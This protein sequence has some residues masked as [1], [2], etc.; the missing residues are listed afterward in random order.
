VDKNG[1]RRCDVYERAVNRVLRDRLLEPRRAAQFLHGPRQ[2][3]KTTTVL[4]VL[5][6]LPLKSHYAS[7]DAPE[8]QT[9]SWIREQ[10]EIARG[11]HRTQGTPV[12]LALDEVQKVAL[13]SDV[14][15]ALWDE[16][17][18]AGR[19]IRVTLLGSAPWPMGRGMRESMAGRYE[20]VR[21]TH[22]TFPECR[23]AFGWDLA[24]FVFF[25][26]YPGAVSF[27]GDWERWRGYVMETAIEATVSRDVLAMTRIDK[28]SLLRQTLYLGCEYSA[29]EL[30]LQKMRGALE[31]AGSLATLAHY[32][33]LLDEAGLIAALQKHASQSARR[34]ASVP[35]LQVRNNA[36][37]S[38]LGAAP[39]ETVRADAA[40]WGRI[41]ESAVGAYL[42]ER[43]SQNR[44][45]LGYWRDGT[46]E[47]D[48]VYSRG[49]R[50]V[51][52]E[53]KTAHDPRAMRGLTAFKDA[54]G[55][56]PE[57]LVVG[58][59]GMAVAEFLSGGAGI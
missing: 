10:W 27:I 11:M 50:L 26:G 3:G 15:K 9:R 20:V 55:G 43:A 14:V 40:R 34:R 25:G 33:E 46:S 17:T 5:D 56:D 53:V 58:E 45:E 48:F 28:P 31:D 35:K 23:D 32:L 54:F 1:E 21:A 2:V 13:W 59:G 7:A 6:G 24:T 57:L 29:R 49:D 37:M 39:I 44:A 47:V 41:V 8:A 38:A 30:S 42:A 51:A 16:D 19:D 4:M 12:V 36:L 22:W 18:R 52:I